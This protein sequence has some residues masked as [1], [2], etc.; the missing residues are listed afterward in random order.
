MIYGASWSFTGTALAKFITLVAGIVCAHLMSKEDYGQFNMLRS[1][2]NMFVVLGAGGLGIAA[3]KFI[4]Q[5]RH[6]KPQYIFPLYIVS[7]NFGIVTGALCTIGVLIFAPIFALHILHTTSLVLPLRM[8]GVL[9]FFSILNGV[10]NGALAGLEDF[11]SIAKNTLLGSIIEAIFMLIGAWWWNISGAILGFGLGFIAIY[12][13]NKRS[14]G[15]NFRKYNINKTP[16]KDVH[17]SDIRKVLTISIPATC[18]ALLIAPTFWVLRTILVANG[19]YEELAVFEAADQWK[20]VM[21]FVPTAISQIALPILSSI[22]NQ[23][24]SYV[25]TLKLNIILIFAISSV[26][27]ILIGILSPLIMSFYGWK[28][29]HTLPLQILALSTIF[30]SVS[31][32]LEMCVYSKGRIWNAFLFNLVWAISAIFIALCMLN[33]ETGATGLSIAVLLSYVVVCTL[34]GLYVWRNIKNNWQK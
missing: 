23:E 24:R 15:L 9:L 20:V 34:F 11:R 13:T 32:V 10:Q 8:G 1:T 31:H 27:T 2:I 21:L 7:N 12:I 19:G 5:Y 29:A 26:F 14:I 33:C 16:L 3:T 25:H 17:K 28:D 18:S 6:D 22:Q 30:S 4:S